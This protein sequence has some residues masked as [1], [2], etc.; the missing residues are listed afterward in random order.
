MAQ[1]KGQA[2]PGNYVDDVTK[3][4][5]LTKLMAHFNLP[6]EENVDRARHMEEAVKELL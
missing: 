1:P 5:R 6:L 2:E 3:R 4:N